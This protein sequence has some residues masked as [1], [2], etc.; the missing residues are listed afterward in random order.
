MCLACVCGVCAWCVLVGLC[1]CV[2]H[3]LEGVCVSDVC[4][5]G[6]CVFGVCWSWVCVCFVYV[7]EGLWCVL[8]GYVSGVC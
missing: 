2:W 3:V 8:V 6:G 7:G 5:W 4:W 1:V